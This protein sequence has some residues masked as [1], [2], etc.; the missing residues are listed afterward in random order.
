MNKVEIVVTGE[1]LETLKKESKTAKLAKTMIKAKVLYLRAMGKTEKEIV[2]K[3]DVSVSTIISYVR[4]FNENGIKSIYRTKHKGQSSKL[5]DYAEEIMKDFEETPPKTIAE[6]A[7][8]IHKKTGLVRTYNAVRLFL[9]KRGFHT[10]NQ[11]VYQQ[12]QIRKNNK[13]L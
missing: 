8:R 9:L 1:E 10:K 11:E 6:A 2:L 3:T 4:D 5:N 12:K 7:A 13:N